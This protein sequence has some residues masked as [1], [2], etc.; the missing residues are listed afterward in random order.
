MSYLSNLP[1][2][3]RQQ[4]KNLILGNRFNLMIARYITKATCLNITWKHQ[5]NSPQ[6][7]KIAV[8]TNLHMIPQ[9]NGH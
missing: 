4:L 1:F 7:L 2:K 5:N 8:R 3:K 9:E 6:S